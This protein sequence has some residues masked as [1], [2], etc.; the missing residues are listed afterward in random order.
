MQTVGI[1]AAAFSTIR[2]AALA[3]M[4]ARSDAR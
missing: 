1:E 4:A 3:R 2:P